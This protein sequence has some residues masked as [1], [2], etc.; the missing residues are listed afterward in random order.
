MKQSRLGGGQ[1]S[2]VCM[3][4]SSATAAS[5]CEHLCIAERATP[6]ARTV[7]GG[8]LSAAASVSVS[9]GVGAPVLSSGSPSVTIASASSSALRSIASRRSSA[10]RHSRPRA[11][12]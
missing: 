4:R 1:R 8:A 2:S 3:R 11:H 6:Y 9:I 5:H 10:F 12:G 7:A